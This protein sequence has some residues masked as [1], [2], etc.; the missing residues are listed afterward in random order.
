MTSLEKL[1]QRRAK[2]AK[3]YGKY[4]SKIMITQEK[5]VIRKDIKRIKA[6]KLRARFG[7]TKGDVDKFGKRTEEIVSGF[8]SGFKKLAIGTGKV[9]KALGE[10]VNE[11][12]E[13]QEKQKKKKKE[14]EWRR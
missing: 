6:A 4:A 7:M 13:Q 9:V 8:G 10:T 3:T 2:E 11:M 1:K 12:H 14:F 5:L